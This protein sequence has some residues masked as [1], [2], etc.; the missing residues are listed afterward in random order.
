MFSPDGKLLAVAG[1]EGSI[2]IWDMTSP[3]HPVE[4]P[5][6]SG[7]RGGVGIL[8]ISRRGLLAVGGADNRILL[9]DIRGQYAAQP[10]AVLAGPRGP[11]HALAFSPDGR[12]LA[13]AGT[14]H[15]VRLWNVTN[16]AQPAAPAAAA[17]AVA[18]RSHRL[19]SAPA[20]ASWRRATPTAGSGC[21]G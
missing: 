17:G 8:A 9:W 7:P 2:R 3:A 13:A 21:G 18:P 11:A 10:A 15:S 16:P 20:G 4:R 19:L 1:D 5:A 12:L 6:L 14:D